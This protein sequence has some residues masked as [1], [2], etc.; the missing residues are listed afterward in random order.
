MVFLLPIFKY[1]KADV[2]AYVRNKVDQYVNEQE[3]LDIKLSHQAQLQFSKIEHNNVG[4]GSSLNRVVGWVTVCRA[5]GGFSFS[6]EEA[7]TKN[8][9][10]PKKM[11]APL[12]KSDQINEWHSVD[13]SMITTS[14]EA[15]NLFEEVFK[16]IELKP[17]FKGCQIDRSSIEQIY[18][19]VDWIGFINSPL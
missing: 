12:P 5:L 13:F 15:L 16:S 3:Q 17:Q 10:I 4:A 9:N 18:Q 19:F 6:V 2:D 14:L 8:I 1:T 7:H 11:Y